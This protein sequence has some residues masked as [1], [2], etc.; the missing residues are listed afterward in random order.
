MT[1]TGPF[2]HAWPTLQ[3]PEA[4]KPADLLLVVAPSGPFNRALFWRGVAWL[5]SRYRVR[6]DR[7]VFTRTGFLAGDDERRQCELQ[8]ALDDREV[9]AIVMVRGGHGLLR[10]AHGLDFSRWRTRPSWLVGFS[11]PTLL[12]LEAWRHGV[13]SLHAA[14]VVSLGRAQS[15]ARQAWQ[16]AIEQP[17][18][19]RRLT[20]TVEGPLV[21]GNLTVLHAAAAAGRLWLPP[22]CILALEDV[23]ETSYRID[24]MLCALELGGHLNGVAGLALGE[25]L[26]CSPG[27]HRVPTETVLREHVSRLGLPTVAALPFGHGNNNQPLLLGARARLDAAAGTLEVGCTDATAD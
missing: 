3:L 5:A 6:F 17:R 16:L 12:H 15:R 13:A 18:H 14:N 4:L 7:S 11:D 23:T 26:D 10:I 24:R 22:G 19:P 1:P 21:G 25:F 8:A 2:L 9:R 27:V 20:G